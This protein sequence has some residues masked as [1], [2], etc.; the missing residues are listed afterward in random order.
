MY[1][2]V[3]TNHSE[4]IEEYRPY[5][6][7]STF[8]SEK[9]IPSPKSGNSSGISNLVTKELQGGVPQQLTGPKK[10][11]QTFLKNKSKWGRTVNTYPM[12]PPISSIGWAKRR[13]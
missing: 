9:F 5:D 3:K 6:H 4:D 10:R 1:L 13:K 7:F 11:I 8:E 12:L 2:Q